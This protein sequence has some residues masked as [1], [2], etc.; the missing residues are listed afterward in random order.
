M[1]VLFIDNFDSFTYNLVDEFAKRDCK[2]LVYRNNTPMEKI[3]QII[4]EF[5]P[6]LIVISPGPSAPSEAG[7]S[8]PIIKEFAG[9][10]P[11]FGV[12]LGHQA[13]IEA[14]GGKVGRCSETVHGK[15]SEIEHD[16]KTIFEKIEN[17]FEAGRYHSLTG[18]NI[19]SCLEISA[20]TGNIVMGV[21]HKEYFVEGVQFHPESILT[22]EGGKIIENLIKRVGGH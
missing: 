12:C 16:G 10:I 19:P 13:I 17:K 4:K 18:L 15:P 5:K 20:R 1:N 14:F 8:I 11:I 7:N 21:R 6:G 9:K 3:G 2:V 22:G